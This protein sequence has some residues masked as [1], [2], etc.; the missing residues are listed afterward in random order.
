MVITR[1]GN[2]GIGTTNPTGKLTV[3]SST[4]DYTNSLVVNTAWPSITLDGTGTTGRTWSILN[5]ASGAGIGQGNFGIF[6][7]TGSAYR[8]SIDSSGNVG[9]GVNTAIYKLQVAGTG[10]FG[11]IAGSKKG[12]F[13][14]NEDS[15]G[16]TPCIQGVSS[17]LGTNSI[18]LN[19]GGGNIGL[20]RI[21]A[22][23]C[24]V[25]SQTSTLTA[26][27]SFYITPGPA[28]TFFPVVF[29]TNAAH[30]T[31]QN[32]WKI[33]VARTSVHQD[34][35]WRGSLMAEFWGNSSV[36]GNGADSFSY[37]I[38]GI[39]SGATY[40]YFVGNAAV[41]FTS[42]W[43]V[44]YLRGGTTYQYSCKGASLNYY[45][46][47]SPFVSY[48]IPAGNNSVVYAT[49]T[50]TAPFDNTYVQYDGVSGLTNFGSSNAGQYSSR[51]NN[52]VGGGVEL[53]GTNGGFLRG[54]LHRLVGL[55]NIQIAYLMELM[56]LLII[57]AVGT[58]RDIPF[59]VILLYLVLI[60]QV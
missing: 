45:P 22:D 12:I 31:G 54:L 8:L 55:L 53:Y 57:S 9:I 30:D 46:S 5:G 43:L 26:Y 49:N 4:A 35:T 21:T 10:L 59:F 42:G 3:Y 14:A 18:S 6:D 17:G 47:S 11:Y 51:L 52:R 37:N 36:W 25:E 40:N 1:D 58:V 13:I 20:G 15:Y 23:L 33:T 50:P 16:T 34:A 38:A 56:L 28:T 60:N 44:V 32:T 27:S 41:D 48:T 19:P 7:I 29:N 39:T 2:V 24:R